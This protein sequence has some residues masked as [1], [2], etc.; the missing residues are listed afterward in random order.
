MYLILSDADGNATPEV[1]HDGVDVII[2]RAVG[3]CPTEKIRCRRS[4]QK[5]GYWKI[6]KRWLTPEPT[7]TLIP[8]EKREEKNVFLLLNE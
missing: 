4:A 7:M 2:L 5:D 1:F 3:E 8:C 6:G